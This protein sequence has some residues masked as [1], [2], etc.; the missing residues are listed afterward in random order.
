MDKHLKDISQDPSTWTQ[1]RKEWDRSNTTEIASFL[2]DP[3]KNTTIFSLKF[4]IRIIH[5]IYENLIYEEYLIL[6]AAKIK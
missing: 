2:D 6:P 3:Q 5:G 4:Y 1:A